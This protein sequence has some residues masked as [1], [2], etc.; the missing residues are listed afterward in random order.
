MNPEKLAKLQANANRSKGTPRR[1][2]KKVH[3]S[4]AQ[5][6]RKLQGALE[7]LA[8]VPQP[9]VDEVNMFMEEGTVLNFRQPKVH[10]SVAS[11][12]YAIYGRGQE[13]DMTELIPN[14]LSQLGPDSIANL[15]KLAESY[16]KTAAGQAALANQEDDDEVPDLVESFEE[17][18]IEASKEEEK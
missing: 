1:V 4:V 11:N 15:R 12:T 14:I 16:Q 5:D 13:K 2:V 6:D 18:S 17:A 10:A 3:R 7:K 9:Y 8:L